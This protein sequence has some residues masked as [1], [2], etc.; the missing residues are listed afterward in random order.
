MEESSEEQKLSSGEQQKS[1]FKESY[2][3][4]FHMRELNRFSGV[5]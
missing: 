1:K 4:I 2:E 5:K 3:M